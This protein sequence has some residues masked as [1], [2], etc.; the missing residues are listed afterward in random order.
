MV[1]AAVQGTELIQFDAAIYRDLVPVGYEEMAEQKN[2][3]LAEWILWKN[4]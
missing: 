4:G 1:V 3:H 2:E